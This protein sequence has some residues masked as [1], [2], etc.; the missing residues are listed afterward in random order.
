MAYIITFRDRLGL[1]DNPIIFATATA[2]S[3]PVPCRAGACLHRCGLHALL[4]RLLHRLALDAMGR[5][6]EV[7]SDHRLEPV[8]ARRATG[9]PDR[10]S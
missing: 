4:S 7:F 1:W 8:R 6:A 3:G 5:M 9:G 2:S 10:A